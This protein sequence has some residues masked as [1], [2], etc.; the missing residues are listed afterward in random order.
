M[1]DIDTKLLEDMVR[2]IITESLSKEKCEFDKHVDPSGVMSVKLNTVKLCKFDTGKEGDDVL[3]KDV[4]TLEESPRLGCG[5][6]EMKETRFDWT[7][8]YDEIDYVIDG[9]LEVNIEGRKVIANKG[10]IILIPKN[11]K[12]EFSAPN[13]A[14]FMFVTYPAN[15]SELE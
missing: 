6:M 4:V 14:K 13:Y 12:I 8:K 2:K 15:W 9:T 3:L 10:E 5:L 11:S 7:L 1:E